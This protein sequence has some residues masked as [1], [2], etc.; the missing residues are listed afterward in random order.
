MLL[1]SLNSCQSSLIPPPIFQLN[2]AWMSTAL[3]QILLSMSS[4]PISF[5]RAVNGSSRNFTVCPG[6]GPPWV[7]FV[8]FCWQ[9]YPS[10]SRYNNCRSSPSQWGHL[11]YCGGLGRECYGYG[12]VNIL[13]SSGKGQAR[14]G[15]GWQ[16]RRKAS[17]L[18]PLPRAYTKVGCHLPTT[19]TTT[20]PPPKSLISIFKSNHTINNNKIYKIFQPC[21]YMCTVICF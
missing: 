20:H 18:K 8:N 17:K 10:T 9:L 16:S 2:L 13:W 14:I 15:K 7:L 6:K 4:V 1:Y 5:I 12:M 19:T 3:E 21:G 11:L